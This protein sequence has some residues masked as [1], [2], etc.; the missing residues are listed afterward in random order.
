MTPVTDRYGRVAVLYGGRSGERAVSLDSGAAVL[1]ALQTAGLDAIPFDPAERE[2]G[3][4]RG[5]GV[6]RVWNALHGGAGEDGTLQ[7]ALAMLELPVTGSGV[8]ASAL[9]MDK[10]RS[11]A[12]LRARGVNTVGGHAVRRGAALPSD[13]QYP[14]FVKPASGGSSL[15]ARPVTESSA[16][17]DALAAEHALDDVA[18]IE[19]LLPGPEY[20]VGILGRSALPAIRIDAGN[21]FYD[22]DAKYESEATKFT[23][24]AFTSDNELAQRL[25]APV[26]AGGG[27]VISCWMAMAR[28][29]FWK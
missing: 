29:A 18:L 3:E 9:A 8:L 14:V 5:E 27:A 11:K 7:G 19:P 1:A 24:P 15:G 25:A 2:L 28:P 4:L 17:T 6:H 13:V 20:T 22:Y 21:V 23:C 26:A 12:V 10:E 16:L